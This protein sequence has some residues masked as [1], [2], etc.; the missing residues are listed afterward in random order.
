MSGMG[1]RTV[2]ALPSAV[3][4]QSQSIPKRRD[5]YLEIVVSRRADQRFV[6]DNAIA[7]GFSTERGIREST[8]RLTVKAPDE[9]ALFGLDENGFIIAD[10]KEPSEKEPK[11]WD[12]GKLDEAGPLVILSLFKIVGSNAGISIK[13]LDV[14][15]IA[16]E[17]F[18]DTPLPGGGLIR[19]LKMGESIGIFE[20]NPDA[21]ITYSP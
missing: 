2:R 11:I 21:V 5:D 14:D 12:L 10:Q 3:P 20:P 16:M 15:T 13:T 18:L 1:I 19:T 8:V 4:P 9:Y 17:E 6:I 7:V